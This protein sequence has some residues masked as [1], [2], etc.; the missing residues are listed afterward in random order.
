MRRS[1]RSA[2][3][4]PP[5]GRPRPK[6][7]TP[8]LRLKAIRLYLEESIPREMVAKE[9]GVCDETV[10][11]WVKRYQAEG[12]AGLQ[13]HPRASGNR[14]HGVPPAVKEKIAEVKRAHPRFGIRRIAQT[15]RR[16]LLLPG[17]A[18]TVRRTLHE[19]K[20][21]DPKRRRAKRKPPS[22]RFFERSTP[23][24]LWQSD[25]FCFRL[26]GKNAYLIGYIDDYSRY[27]VGLDLFRSQTG[28]HLLEVYRTA[29]GE[30]GVPREMLTDNG[31]Q[32]TNWRGKTRFEAEMR[33]DRVHHFRSRPHHP[34]TLGKIERF[35]KTIWEEFLERAQFE[36]YE[37][38]RERIRLWVKYYNHR[39]PHQGI[40]GLCPADRFFEI[41]KGLREVIE[42]GIQENVEEL[43][44]RGEV[45]SPFYMVGRMGEQSVVI[46][47]E[48]GKVR[49]LVEGEEQEKELVYDLEGGSRGKDSGRGGEG[50]EGTGSAQR[51]GT[52]G[53]G[54]GNMDGAAKAGGGMPGAGVEGGGVT[55]VAGSGATGYAGCAG[56]EGNG[57]RPGADASGAAGEAAPA[58]DGGACGAADAAVAA[59]GEDTGGEGRG[60]DRLNGV[61]DE[62]RGQ[63]GGRSGTREGG[64]DHPGARGGDE[65]PGGGEE[66]WGIEE[67]I[68]QVGGESAPGDGGGSGGAEEGKVEGAKRSGKGAV[69]EGAG[70]APGE[71][72]GAGAATE[73]T[74][75][76]G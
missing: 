73:D 25:I 6:K 53:G 67:N 55:T 56:T 70:R 7:C 42:G 38:A 49:M 22:P 57:D 15:L 64:G 2:P 1:R 33:K 43:A 24:Q 62:G 54:A 63:E 71:A 14:K 75:A 11:A 12:E 36:S 30:Y 27:V 45:R 51:E 66:A 29:V 74:G 39:R 20:L 52:G 69:E 50:E 41:Q 47:A 65:R 9:L 13:D 61:S 60:E 76:A 35:W 32:Y 44:L 18:E 19:K 8:D 16:V 31:R 28:E 72:E 59:A 5:R 68:L 37:S 40:G 48:K 23:N 21:L 17:S 26:G 58:A 46:R 3:S 10:R 34:M 4:S